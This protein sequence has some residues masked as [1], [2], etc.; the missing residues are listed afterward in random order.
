MDFE[1]F[2]S[3]KNGGE[4]VKMWYYLVNRKAIS[5]YWDPLGIP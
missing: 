1:K 5:G 4:F 2:F 3:T